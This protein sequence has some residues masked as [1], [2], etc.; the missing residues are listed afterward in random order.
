MGMSTG[1]KA[2]A[3]QNQGTEPEIWGTGRFSM[4]KATIHLPGTMLYG[5]LY[6]P[7]GWESCI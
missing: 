3:D 1:N 6:S 4:Q 2:Q 7:I 5:L